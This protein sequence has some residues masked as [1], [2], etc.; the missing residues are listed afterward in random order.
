MYHLSLVSH[1]A[2]IIF[3]SC[4][5]FSELELLNFKKKLLKALCPCCFENRAAENLVTCFSIA[6]L[7]LDQTAFNLRT[8]KMTLCLY[9]SSQNTKQKVVAMETQYK[10]AA[11]SAQLLAKDASQDEAARVMATMATAKSQL[12]KVGIV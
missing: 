8:S 7:S 12:S 6:K 4:F 1:L 3:P 10:L 5:T 2:F 11:R 9:L